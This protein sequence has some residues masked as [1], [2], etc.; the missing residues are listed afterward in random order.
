M[1]LRAS[2]RPLVFLIFL[3][4][5]TA[6]TTAPA[7]APA[8]TA[9]AAAA[10]RNLLLSSHLAPAP[11]SRSGLR[12]RDDAGG[13]EPGRLGLA[14]GIAADSAADGPA[15]RQRALVVARLRVDADSGSAAVAGL[16]LRA[17]EA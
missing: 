9:A 3:S 15:R 17:L 7:A 2:R 11:Q 14:D 13:R 16:G 6:S 10:S 12:R 4:S 1:C 5:G 8:A